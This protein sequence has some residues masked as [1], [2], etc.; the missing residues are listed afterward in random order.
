MTKKTKKQAKFDTLKTALIDIDDEHKHLTKQKLNV[1]ESLDL[2]QSRQSTLM[3]DILDC[4]QCGQVW[5][6]DGDRVMILSIGK[7]APYNVEV[8]D[9]INLTTDDRYIGYIVMC[10]TLT[11]TIHQMKTILG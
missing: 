2:I 6:R 10:Y 5:S 4:M 1:C 8:L 3:D 7:L 11:T 9:L